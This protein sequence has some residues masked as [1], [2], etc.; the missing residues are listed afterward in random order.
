MRGKLG[1]LRMLGWAAWAGLTSYHISL[2]KGG[3]QGKAGNTKISH[4]TRIPSSESMTMP[5]SS[6]EVILNGTNCTK[7]FFIPTRM[8]K[9]DSTRPSLEEDCGVPRILHE[10]CTLTCS[11]SCTRDLQLHMSELHENADGSESPSEPSTMKVCG[12]QRGKREMG[13]DHDLT[14]FCSKV[15]STI[16]HIIPCSCKCGIYHAAFCTRYLVSATSHL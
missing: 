4:D 12:S 6:C 16:C 8:L 14:T 10:L 7:S 5:S 11:G 2:G 15:Y 13:S 9:F 1:S 3:G